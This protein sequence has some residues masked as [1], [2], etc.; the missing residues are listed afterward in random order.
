MGKM[1][2]DKRMTLGCQ[3]TA[4]VQTGLERER[5]NAFLR[6]Q[7]MLQQQT[8][9]QQNSALDDISQ[10]TQRLGHM[11]V[12]IN[13]RLKE[14]QILLAQLDDDVGKQSEKLNFVMKR[15][16]RLMQTTD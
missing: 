14:D 13:R 11:A 3:R 12:T 7:E 16:G 9:S 5:T 2:S 15:L 8:I 10:S 1:E 6:D 4:A